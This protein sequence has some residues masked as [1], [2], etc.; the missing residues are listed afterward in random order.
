MTGYYNEITPKYRLIAGS[1]ID[2][3][4]NIIINSDPRLES[5][6]PDYLRF[7]QPLRFSVVELEGMSNRRESELEIPISRYLSLNVQLNGF[8]INRYSVDNILA[9]I[10]TELTD[11]LL[12][13]KKRLEKE[14]NDL[15]SLDINRFHPKVVEV[16]G[17][18]FEDGHY[19]Q[20]ILD[21]YIA[22]CNEVQLKARCL[23]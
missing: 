9:A 20:A 22:L 19:R 6:K 10:R 16:A 23:I 5:I 3:Q 2:L 15:F 8:R 13:L 21:T 12:E 11:R 7:Y 17:K 18:L 14:N 1:Y 4:G